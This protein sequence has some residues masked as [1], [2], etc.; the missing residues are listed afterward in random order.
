MNDE[1]LALV[2]YNYRYYNPADGRW[3]NRDPIYNNKN[4]Y[5]FI[6][7]SLGPIDLLGLDVEYVNTVLENVNFIEN[8]GEKNGRILGK[9]TTEITVEAHIKYSD[10]ENKCCLVITY[11][12]WRI[13]ISVLNDT[14]QNYSFNPQNDR[15]R[16]ILDRIKA[17]INSINDG[18]WYALY[19]IGEATYKGTVIH[20]LAHRDQYLRI[21]GKIEEYL[22]RGKKIC[23]DANNEKEVKSLEIMKN[24]YDKDKFSAISLTDIIEQNIGGVETVEAEATKKE[25]FYYSQ[26]F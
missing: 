12:K 24:N 7:N 19:G 13:K 5:L 21:K 15:V 22:N 25:W 6:N 20:E 1:E 9:T 4:S 3:I 26:N 18:M 17:N 8:D 23:K 10:D 11:K 16:F 2:Y 14:P